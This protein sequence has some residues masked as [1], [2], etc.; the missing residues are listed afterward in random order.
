[1]ENHHS[2]TNAII[3]DYLFQD[4]PEDLEKILTTAPK[5]GIEIMPPPA[6]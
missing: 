5:Y 2:A 6:S 1:M 3:G 4:I